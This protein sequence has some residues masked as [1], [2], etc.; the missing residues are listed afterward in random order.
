MSSSDELPILESRFDQVLEQIHLLVKDIETKRMDAG[1][2]VMVDD[3]KVDVRGL[4]EAC[5][6][7]AAFA[8]LF[9]AMRSMPP[10]T[11]QQIVEQL[12]TIMP[13]SERIAKEAPLWRN[14]TAP[15]TCQPPQTQ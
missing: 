13:R 10:Q 9:M 5:T 3:G 2:V 12:G 14:A 6:P 4:G 11:Q 7:A 1:V 15:N 8:I